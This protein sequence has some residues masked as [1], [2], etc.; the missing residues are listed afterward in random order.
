MH[1]L[2]IH[3]LSKPRAKRHMHIDCNA[4]ESKYDYRQL[5]TS[6]LGYRRN[7]NTIDIMYACK[8]PFRVDV[9]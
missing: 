2:D 3:I 5:S 8:K 7:T 1:K 4:T 6:S 9:S